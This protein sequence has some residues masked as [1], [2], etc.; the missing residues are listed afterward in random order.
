MCRRD[1]ILAASHV[2]AARIFPPFLCTTSTKACTLAT[3]VFMQGWHGTPA[4][5]HYYSPQV[6]SVTHP[7]LQPYYKHKCC[8][9]VCVWHDN[10]LVT[11]VL[12]A[13]SSLDKEPH[14]G[15]L[16]KDILQFRNKV[17]LRDKGRLSIRLHDAHIVTYLF[18]SL[19]NVHS[20]PTDV[21]RVAVHITYWFSQYMRLLSASLFINALPWTM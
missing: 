17:I 21:Q 1:D 13:S 11:A 8:V 9:G 16:I 4:C 12:H 6:A 3:G 18:Q 20:L 2:I 10:V 5:V 7:V 15:G 14:A 19:R